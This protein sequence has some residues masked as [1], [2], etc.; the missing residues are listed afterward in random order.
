LTVYRYR[1]HQMSNKTQ[2]Y[3]DFQGMFQIAPFRSS[4]RQLGP[5]VPVLIQI[6]L[7]DSS[8]LCRPKFIDAGFDSSLVWLTIRSRHL[9]FHSMFYDM[10]SVYQSGLRSVQGTAPKFR[11]L[12]LC[13]LIWTWTRQ[14]T[15]AGHQK[16]KPHEMLHD[17]FVY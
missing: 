14:W 7:I 1:I 12:I 16:M 5:S 3:L 17:M 8:T 9:S 2:S 13:V 4:W 6:I 11:S 15:G 10:I